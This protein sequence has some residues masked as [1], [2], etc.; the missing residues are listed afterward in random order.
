MASRQTVSV[1]LDDDR[2]RRIEKAAAIVDEPAS[3]FLA[4]V[5]DRR[6]HN[7]LLDWAVDRYRTG[8]T[9]FG[10]LADETGL[11]VEEIMLA[12]GRWGRDEALD[13]F[14]DHC[15]AL[16]RRH[17]SPVLLELAERAVAQVRAESG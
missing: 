16:A 6:A 3:D 2:R 15:K 9:T 4:Q 12:M 14:L 17:H 1:R 5:A 13:R 10:E 11:A 7:V 8:E